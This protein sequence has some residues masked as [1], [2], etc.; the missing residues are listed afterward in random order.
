MGQKIGIHGLNMGYILDNMGKT[1][2]I[3]GSYMG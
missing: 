2:G 3:Y 1:K